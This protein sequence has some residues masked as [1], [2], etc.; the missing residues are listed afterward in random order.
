MSESNIA[1]ALN[2][3]KAAAYVAAPAT[4][5]AVTP[6]AGSFSPP[7]NRQR[8]T[9]SDFM[10]SARTSVDKY[11]KVSEHGMTIGTEL[12]ALVESFEATI[13]L[14]DLKFCQ[15]VRFGNNP[16]Q[17]FKTYD[18]VKSTDGRSWNDVLAQAKSV[19][20]NR[21]SDPYPTAEMVLTLVDQV[22]DVKGQPVKDATAGVTLG[23]TPPY[24][25]APAL[26]ELM[27]AVEE[28]GGDTN[29]ST[30]R[31]KVSSEGQNR[32]GNSWGI[33]KFA[34]IELVA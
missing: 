11:L 32:N 19:V 31:V 25:G 6:A 30:V 15:Q 27:K 12:K 21:T 28:A 34:L 10:N 7:A 2:F 5:T 26:A 20:Q 33:V 18:G 17:Y 29:T 24:T 13:K 1:L 8:M 4:S 22:K 14:S 16:V 3:A 23:Y 9:A